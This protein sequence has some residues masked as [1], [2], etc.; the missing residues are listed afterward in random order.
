V[1]LALGARRLL[2]SFAPDFFDSPERIETSVTDS[3]L[4]E[5][6]QWLVQLGRA[7]QRPAAGTGRAGLT[8]QTRRLIGAPLLSEE[9]ENA[10]T[11]R[12][13]APRCGNI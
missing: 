3:S 7:R 5:L 12:N 9:I 2:S 4:I 1:P 11:L 8:R 10:I 13:A 6:N